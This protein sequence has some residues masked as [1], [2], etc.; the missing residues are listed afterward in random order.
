MPRYPRR[1]ES[2]A[3]LIGTDHYDNYETLSA[4]TN[5][6]DVLRSVLISAKRGGFLPEHC[7]AISN[8][9]EPV[10]LAEHIN[11]VAGEATDVLMVYCSGHGIIDPTSRRLQLA[12]EHT[13]EQSLHYTALSLE[14]LKGAIA[15]SPAAMKVLI[16]ECCYS[17]LAIAGFAMA[18]V[19]SMLQQQAEMRG[20]YTLTSSAM[21]EISLAP[22]GAEFTAFSGAFI[23]LLREPPADHPAGATLAE[24]YPLLKRELTSQNYPEPQ[25]SVENSAG[26]LALV[27]WDNGGDGDHEMPVVLV[28]PSAEDVPA[29]PGL[30][31][32]EH[33]SAVTPEVARLLRHADCMDVE[34]EPLTPAEIDQRLSELLLQAKQIHHDDD[35]NE[36]PTNVLAAL[37]K[38]VTTMIRIG[39]NE[40]PAVLYARDLQGY[41]LAKA[42][43]SGEAKDMFERI[44]RV[45]EKIHGA[46]HPEVLTTRQNL[47]HI[48]GLAGNAAEAARQFQQLVEDR[49]RILGHD[50]ADTQESLDS[51][52]YWAGVSG[53]QEKAVGIYQK[54]LR[55]RDWQYGSTDE[56]TLDMQEKL[57]SWAGLAGGATL[58][59]STYDQLIMNWAAVQGPNG[60]NV[61]RSRKYRDYWAAK[62][63]D[64][65]DQ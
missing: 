39:G 26:D 43:R 15:S 58:A 21:D 62:V 6:L 35:V 10:G 42:G 17:G 40:H 59:R 13:R 5:N 46:E 61:E 36:M 55:E 57:A 30:A 60:R 31:E 24:M 44:L 47:A 7:H 50:H 63:Q 22:P 54:L 18:D 53:D 9:Q 56:R 32:D 1:D 38:I 16:L 11:D 37:G 48:I 64:E 19:S 52:A 41:W 34:P 45:R 23:R 29:A 3:I 4:I 33:G 51:L 49:E 65:E 2:R 12:L 8:P 27:G 14:L 28:G 25:Q 20:V